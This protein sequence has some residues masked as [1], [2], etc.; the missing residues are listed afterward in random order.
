MEKNDYIFGLRAVMEALESGRH[1]DKVLMRRDL[2][3]DLAKELSQALKLYRYDGR[4]PE[5]P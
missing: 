5:P 2:S 4:S 1:I 3:G